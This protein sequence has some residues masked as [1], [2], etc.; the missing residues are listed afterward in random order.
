MEKETS[1]PLEKRRNRIAARFPNIKDLNE[2]LPPTGS[3]DVSSSKQYDQRKNSKRNIMPAG[4]EGE[5]IMSGTKFYFDSK[6]P[7]TDGNFIFLPI[8]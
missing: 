2:S 8:L 3:L 4:A 5:Q 1:A 7:V 6:E